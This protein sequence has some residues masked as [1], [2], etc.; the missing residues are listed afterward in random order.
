M[1]LVINGST[2]SFTA[3]LQPFSLRFISDGFEVAGTDAESM[4]A[5]RGFKLNYSQDSTN[6]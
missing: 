1:P 5:Q 2:L 6:C 3:F 4:T